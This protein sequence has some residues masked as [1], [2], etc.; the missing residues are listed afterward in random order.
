MIITTHAFNSVMLSKMVDGDAL[1]GYP[2]YKRK[3]GGG[4][5]PSYRPSLPPQRPKKRHFMRRGRKK[6]WSFYDVLILKAEMSSVENLIHSKTSP[7]I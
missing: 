6:D 7:A 4:F 1:K 3:K 2:S 5:S